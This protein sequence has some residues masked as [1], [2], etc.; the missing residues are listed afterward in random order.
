MTYSPRPWSRH[1][2]D[3]W[4]N[5]ALNPAFP[6]ALRVA[7]LAYGTHRANGH[8]MFRPGEVGK[9]LGRFDEDLGEHVPMDKSNVQRAIRRAV[10]LGLLGAGSG[11]LCL[12]VPAHRIEG[13]LGNPNERCPRHDDERSTRRN[14]HAL[15]SVS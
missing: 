8:A 4:H 15:R 13:G 14:R 2:Q 5:D 3:A 11:T 7:F 9:V 12:I 6:P 10:T 1:Y